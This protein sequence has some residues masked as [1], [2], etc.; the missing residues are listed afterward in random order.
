MPTSVFDQVPRLQSLGGQRDAGST[1]TNQ[2]REIFLGERKRVAFEQIAYSQKKAGQPLI[3]AMLCVAY[4]RLLR[5][6]E[7]H[8]IRL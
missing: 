8:L 4:R 5:V 3:N 7:Q 6:R 2:L 1:D